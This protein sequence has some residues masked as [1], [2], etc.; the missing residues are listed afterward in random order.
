MLL[1]FADTIDTSI[2]VYKDRRERTGFN[3]YA[4]NM[5]QQLTFLDLLPCLGQRFLGPHQLI[6]KKQTLLRC[7]VCLGFV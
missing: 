4:E 5:Q 1:F 7:M 6:T 3:M 2:L